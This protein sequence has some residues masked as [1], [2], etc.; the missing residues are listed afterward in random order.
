[1]YYVDIEEWQW[2]FGIKPDYGEDKVL[3]LTK[4]ETRSD[5]TT[6]IIIDTDKLIYVFL[7]PKYEDCLVAVFAIAGPFRS[8]KSFLQNLLGSYLRR[9]VV[10][11]LGKILIKL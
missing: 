3:Q 2:P 8:G 5:G 6:K 11:F 9:R 7:N 10:S 1:M 4:E